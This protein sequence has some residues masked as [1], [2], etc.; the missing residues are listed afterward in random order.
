MNWE[1]TNANILEVIANSLPKIL[2]YNSNNYESLEQ[3]FLHPLDYVTTSYYNKIIDRSSFSN[4]IEQFISN[5]LCTKY[6]SDEKLIPLSIKLG[7]DFIY[8]PVLSNLSNKYKSNEDFN[9]LSDN[10]KMLLN[11]RTRF[12]E[13]YARLIGGYNINKSAQLFKAVCSYLGSGYE[14]PIIIY[15]NELDIDVKDVFE[16]IYN[17]SYINSDMIL[18][19]KDILQF[20]KYSNFSDEIKSKIMLRPDP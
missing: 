7:N 5:L 12:P 11:I 13:A 10:T 4:S 15:G 3:L 17:T 2:P 16:Q 8:Q 9:L 18:Y 1:I 6:L 20:L 19:E 14:D